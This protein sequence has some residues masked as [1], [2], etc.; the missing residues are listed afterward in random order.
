M[1]DPHRIFNDAQQ[2]AIR[3]MAENVD[4]SE[5]RIWN[6]KTIIAQ[7]GMT[8]SDYQHL[9]HELNR[10]HRQYVILLIGGTLGNDFAVTNGIHLLVRQLDRAP[11][12]DY[13]QEIAIWFK[14]KWWSVPLFVLAVLLP[15]VAGYIVIVNALL[16]WIGWK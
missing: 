4:R 15:A 8:E 16:E 14:S 9:M 1:D 3:W 5:A 2:R 10:E 7:T 13:W 6:E 11:P 12:R